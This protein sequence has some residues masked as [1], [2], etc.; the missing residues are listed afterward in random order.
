MCVRGGGVL[1]TYFKSSSYFAKGRMELS[2]WVQLL[3]EGAPTRISKETFSRGE[4]VQTSFPPLDLP[5]IPPEWS[6]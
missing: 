6:L 2:Q 4:G 1:K 3:L 5:M